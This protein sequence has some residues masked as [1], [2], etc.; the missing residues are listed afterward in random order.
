MFIYGSC[1]I[2]SISYYTGSNG[3]VADE[4]LIEKDVEGSDHDPIRGIIPPFGWKY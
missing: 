1:N 4:Y 2:N 3:R